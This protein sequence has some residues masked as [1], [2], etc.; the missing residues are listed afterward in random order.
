MYTNRLAPYRLMLLY[1]LLL[2]AAGCNK[3]P[4]IHS[5]GGSYH[6]DQDGYGFGPG[7]DKIILTLAGDK[8]FDVKAG[9]LL[10]LD[11]TWDL[12]DGKVIFSKGQGAIEVNYRLDGD[13]LVPM[14]EGKDVTGWRWKR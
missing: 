3:G 12:K 14:K 1:V 11:G 4:T 2:L 5:V 6:I 9:P 10:M 8:T 7:A 13:K